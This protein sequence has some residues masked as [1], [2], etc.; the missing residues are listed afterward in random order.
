MGKINKVQTLCP[1]FLEIGG[2]TGRGDRLRIENIGS[3][4]DC[5]RG[6]ALRQFTMILIEK[7]FKMGL[8]KK[9]K[10]LLSRCDF[11]PHNQFLCYKDE[12]DYTTATGGI[13]S[14]ITIIAVMFLVTSE[15]L[16]LVG[17]RKVTSTI[18]YIRSRD[19]SYS[20]M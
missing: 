14:I 19:P 16:D 5:L 11:F 3:A 18:E 6:Q 17:K 12:A 10:Y 20:Q 1:Y 9:V 8:L 4:T 7:K 2:F 13:I 15:A